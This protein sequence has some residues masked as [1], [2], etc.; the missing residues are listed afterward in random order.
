MYLERNTP[1]RPEDIQDGHSPLVYAIARDKVDSAKTLLIWGLDIK[2]QCRNIFL[3][4]DGKVLQPLHAAVIQDNATMVDLL[5]SYHCFIPPNILHPAIRSFLVAFLHGSQVIYSLL[6]YGADAGALD[7]GG[8]NPLHVLLSR[9]PSSGGYL[10]PVVKALVNSGCDP[11]GKGAAGVTPLYLHLIDMHWA[12]SLPWYHSAIA[13]ASATKHALAMLPSLIVGI[14]LDIAEY[15]AC[16][17]TV[18]GA[19]NESTQTF[20]FRPPAADG[21]VIKVQQ[22]EFTVDASPMKIIYRWFWRSLC[23][24]S[25]RRYS[26][27]ID[28]LTWS[29]PQEL[30]DG[31][32]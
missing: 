25:N 28:L 18:E 24:L 31:R 30:I 15:W 29:N 5:L 11:V 23:R 6:N 21:Q 8:D 20:V 1:L 12:R 32:E 10:V 26:L 17:T 7:G 16:C 4:S 3:K 14:I 27:Q 9:R 22:I 2:H 13:A 19:S